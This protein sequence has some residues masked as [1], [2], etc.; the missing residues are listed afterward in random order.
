MLF[1]GILFSCSAQ[2][3]YKTL[4]LFFDGVPNPEE[5]ASTINYNAPGISTDTLGEA[6]D[7][8]R[9]ISKIIYHSPY[10]SKGCDF[11]HD[12][13]SVGTMILDEPDL[14]YQCHENFSDVYPIT[15]GPVDGGFCTECHNPH[16]G[17]EDGL[18]RDKVNNLCFYCHNVEELSE[19]DMH[20]EG[21]DF[22]CTD[23]HSPHGGESSLMFIE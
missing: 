7:S 9:I 17:K 14:C 2:K 18:L 1:C 13:S 20:R 4:S 19:F 5:K 11:C 3:N 12:R 10:Q 22:L 21:D 15:H 23:C 16:S 6:I 8:T